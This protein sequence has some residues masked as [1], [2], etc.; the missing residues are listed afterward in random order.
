MSCDP[1]NYNYIADYR[2]HSHYVQISHLKTPG[3]S[4]GVTYIGVDTMLTSTPDSELNSYK[5]KNWPEENMVK[6]KNGL[7]KKPLKWKVT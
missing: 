5:K 2:L 6:N 7:E 1:S 3:L 4:N